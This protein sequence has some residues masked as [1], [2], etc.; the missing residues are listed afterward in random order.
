MAKPF[1]EGKLIGRGGFAPVYHGTYQN[2]DVAIKKIQID[3][4]NPKKAP[5]EYES[6]KR[7]DHPNVLKLL[8]WQDDA[9]FR[10]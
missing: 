7:L 10:F 5:R 9:D 3:N 1:T 4:L 8:H 2:C 6:M